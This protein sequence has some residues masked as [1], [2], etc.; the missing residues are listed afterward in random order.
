MHLDRAKTAPLRLLSAV[1]LHCTVFHCVSNRPLGLS[2]HGF[3]PGI[4]ALN[5]CFSLRW[6]DFKVSI[7]EEKQATSHW[8]VAVSAII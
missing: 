6:V 4:E 7:Q 8:C 1:S 3:L 5:G 2:A